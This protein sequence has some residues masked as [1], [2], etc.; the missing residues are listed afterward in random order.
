M[1]WQA[2]DRALARIA[3]QRQE[4]ARLCY[5]YPMKENDDD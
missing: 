5:P 2:F 3:R 1:R 4:D